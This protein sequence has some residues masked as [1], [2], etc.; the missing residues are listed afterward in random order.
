[1]QSHPERF[2]K[3]LEEYLRYFRKRE[4]KKKELDKLLCLDGTTLLNIGRK[5]GLEFRI[6]PEVNDHLIQLSEPPM[7]ERRAG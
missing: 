2:Q 7:P 6:P 4:F 3:A 5:R 1:M